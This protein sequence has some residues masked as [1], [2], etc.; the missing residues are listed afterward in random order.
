M[1]EVIAGANHLT[2]T[3]KLCL[4]VIFQGL[5]VQLFNPQWGINVLTTQAHSENS[6][7]GAVCL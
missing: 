3:C 1:P 4:L 5:W 2:K 7:T 6:D